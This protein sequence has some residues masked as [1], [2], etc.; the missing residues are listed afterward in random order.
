MT[1]SVDGDTQ[2]QSTL[3]DKAYMMGVSPYFYTGN[4]STE[5]DFWHCTLTN[6]PDL[7]L[8]QYSKN[9]YS[10]SDTLWYD[11]WSQV[12]DVLPTYVEII[13]CKC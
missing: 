4:F 6:N 1:L 13:T 10:T 9:W 5:L 2:Y 8:P 11:R 7:D 3:G 12:L